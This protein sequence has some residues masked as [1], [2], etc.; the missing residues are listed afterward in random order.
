MAVSRRLRYEV[1]RRDAH[2]CRYC[3]SGAPDVPLT[4]DHVVP[5]ALGGSD[6]P[7][8][9]VTACRDCNSGKSASSP[10]A[11]IVADI[12]QK[13]AEWARAMSVVVEARTAE[14][15]VERTRL[16]LFDEHWDTWYFGND[17][18]FPRDPNWKNSVLRFMAGG[19]D[20]QFLA[21]AVDTAMGRPRMPTGD[22][23][24]YFCGICWREL[25]DLRERTTSLVDSGPVVDHRMPQGAGLDPSFGALNL[26]ESFVVDLLEHLQ[27]P[28]HVPVVVSTFWDAMEEAYRVHRTGDHPE[29][30]NLDEWVHEQFSNVVAPGMNRLQFDLR[31][32]RLVDETT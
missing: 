22:V 32:T 4:V 1:L 7:A 15:A 16:N 18:P 2:R 26:A 30:G 25:D 20:D 31:L 11:P 29:G 9:L 10:D 8:N 27:L 5:V 12:D 23:W 17:E 28:D 21:D 13:A 6:D 19:L 14:L 24:R 3:G